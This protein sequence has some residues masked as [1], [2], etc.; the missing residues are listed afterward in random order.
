MLLTTEARQELD[1]S[2]CTLVGGKDGSHHDIYGY[3][4]MDEPA[5]VTWDDLYCNAACIPQNTID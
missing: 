2:Q 1:K 4:K 3:L 5:G